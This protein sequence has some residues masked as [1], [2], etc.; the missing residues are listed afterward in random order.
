[1]WTPLKE[2]LKSQAHDKTESSTG[3]IEYSLRY[4][5]SNIEEEIWR[6]YEGQYE[7]GQPLGKIRPKMLN[8]ISIVPR[9]DLKLS[10]IYRIC[11]RC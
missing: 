4:Y 9:I 3:K 8:Q 1:M 2:V 10:I 7:Q 11:W 5:E 6:R